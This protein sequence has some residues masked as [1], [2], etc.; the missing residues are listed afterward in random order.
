MRYVSIDS[1]LINACNFYYLDFLGILKRIFAKMYQ[2]PVFN[3]LKELLIS[4]SA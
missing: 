2:Y 1:K 3:Q 4:A